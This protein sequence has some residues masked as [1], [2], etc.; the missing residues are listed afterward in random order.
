M[1]LRWKKRSS[2]YVLGLGVVSL[3]ISTKLL[4]A[5]S[6]VQALLRKKTFSYEDNNAVSNLKLHSNKSVKVQTV[7]NMKSG[8]PRKNFFQNSF[9]RKNFFQSI[10]ATNKTEV[11]E[12]ETEFM[13]K[14]RERMK[15]RS[16]ALEEGC[17]KLGEVVEWL[18][19][20][21]ADSQ[22]V[23][24]PFLKYPNANPTLRFFD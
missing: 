6:E 15:K 19:I 5:F 13:T 14:M 1:R 4:L 20:K 17:R 12:N 9:F 22:Q 18:R 16:D 21:P 11:K 24:L 7:K 8:N 10:S 23:S 2:A 3:I